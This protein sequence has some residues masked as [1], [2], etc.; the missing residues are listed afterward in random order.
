MSKW[1]NPRSALGITLITLALVALPF[2]AVMGG[3]AW[4]RIL[5]ASLTTLPG[6]K[7]GRQAGYDA[8]RREIAQALGMTLPDEVAA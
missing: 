1:L 8:A 3:Q 5:N 6:Y 2:V 4:V 7:V